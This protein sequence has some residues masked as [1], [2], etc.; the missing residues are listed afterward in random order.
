MD[1]LE[2]AKD[3]VFFPFSFGKSQGSCFF[4]FFGKRAKDL[5]KLTFAKFLRGLTL[6]HTLWVILVL[7]LLYTSAGLMRFGT[8]YVNFRS[9]ASC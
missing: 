4:F 6:L 3:L 7:D 5:V 9:L 1:I 8:G 2:I